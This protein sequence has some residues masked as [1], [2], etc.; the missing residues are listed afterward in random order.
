MAT[1][2]SSPDSILLY[3]RD[4]MNFSDLHTIFC[5]C[6]ER[7]TESQ[8]EMDRIKEE[9]GSDS[10]ISRIEMLTVQCRLDRNNKKMQDMTVVVVG[11]VVVTFGF[12][13]GKM[14]TLI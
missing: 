1:P 7:M 10:V 4:W 5:D 9:M 8:V 6:E 2:P 13:V 14:H 11:H 12:L 3:S